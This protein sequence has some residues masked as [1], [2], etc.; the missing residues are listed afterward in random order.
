MLCDVTI[1]IPV[2]EA[3]DYIRDTMESALAQ[4]YPDIEI[5]VVDDCGNDGTIEVVKEFCKSHPRGSQIRILWNECHKGIGQTRNRIIDEARGRCLY[6]LDSDDQIEPD[7]IKLLA[8]EMQL[9]RAELVYGSYEIIDK[10]NYSP[11]R[12]FRKPHLCLEHPDELATFA[13]K[14]QDIFHVTVCNCLIDL[15][16]LRATGLR[17][18]DTM[19]WEDMAFTYELV[20]RASRSVLLPDVTYH[21][22]QRPGSLSH[23]QDRHQLNKEEIMKNVST[24]AYLKAMCNSLKRKK[25]LPFLY[26]NLQMSSFYI[27]CYVLKYRK[28]IIPA[29]SD[30]ELRSIMHFPLTVGELLLFRNNRMQS[31]ALWCIV[32]LPTPLFILVMK[33]MGKAKKIL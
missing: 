19:F 23:Y 24:I 16:F 3:V 28:R 14:H 15:E 11:N 33:A 13:F 10:V 32:H 12:V 9:H 29:I 22:L 31:M 27:V 21:Y 1:G 18:I 26:H 6:F 25:Y 5:L 17:F 20:T 8:E 7:T 2:Y 30:S 4:S